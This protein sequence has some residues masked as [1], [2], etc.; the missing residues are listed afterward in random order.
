MSATPKMMG[1]FRSRRYPLHLFLMRFTSAMDVST[2]SATSVVEA[3]ICSMVSP[4]PNRYPNFRFRDSG[5]KH[6]PKV[7]PTPERPE[8]VEGRA[9]RVS[10]KRLI[11][12]QPRVTKPLMALVPNPK[13]SHIPADRAMTF[14]TAP[15]TSTPMTSL[16]VKHRKE[17]DD[18]ATAKSSAN[19]KS[20][21]AITTA[22]ATPSTISLAKLGPDRNAYERSEPKHSL[23]M[24]AINPKDV[25]SMPLLADNTGTP[26]G[27]SEAMF[28]KNFRLY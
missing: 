27:T 4:W 24:S 23:N 17:S 21:L 10:P 13:P 14:L 1:Y 26:G 25:V 9:P 7:S 5:P 11:S 22:V 15:P 3:K 19:N 16:V 6:V 28:S 12:A 2:P 18:I 8:R 20:S